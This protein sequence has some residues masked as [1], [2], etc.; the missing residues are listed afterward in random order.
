[1]LLE[2]YG[3]LLSQTNVVKSSYVYFLLRFRLYCD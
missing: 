2:L 1:M 3:T